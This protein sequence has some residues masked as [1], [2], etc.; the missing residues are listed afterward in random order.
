[1]T[2]KTSDDIKRQLKITIFSRRINLFFLLLG[3]GSVGWIVSATL[4]RVGLSEMWIRYAI[5]FSTLYFA[6]CLFI[7]KWLN[8]ESKRLLESREVELDLKSEST[9]SDNGERGFISGQFSIASGEGFLVL[10]IVLFAVVVALCLIVAPLLII[11]LVVVEVLIVSVGMRAKNF[12]AEMKFSEILKKTI[13]LGIFFLILS[14]VFG[15]VL[16]LMFPHAE[17]IVQIIFDNWKR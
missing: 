13:P 2:K 10:A 16:S 4:I 5:S 11:D 12:E 3:A 15:F 8:V 1:M 14:T 7:W 9:N 6:F 17:S